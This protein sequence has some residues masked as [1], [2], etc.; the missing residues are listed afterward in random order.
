MYTLFSDMQALYTSEALQRRLGR[1]CVPYCATLLCHSSKPKYH[2]IYGLTD[3][4]QTAKNITDYRDKKR[5]NYQ[6]PT[7]KILT[8]NRHGPTL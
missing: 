7:G 2:I 1:P 5:K 8:D 6:Q 4:R 3:Y